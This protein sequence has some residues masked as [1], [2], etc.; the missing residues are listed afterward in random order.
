[1]PYQPD[2]DEIIFPVVRV[3]QR[4]DGQG[5]PMG[6]PEVWLGRRPEV[7][8]A[9]EIYQE[10]DPAGTAVSSVI[11]PLSEEESLYLENIVPPYHESKNKTAQDVLRA[12]IS[13]A[14]LPE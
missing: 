13:G 4:V 10:V 2:K 6:D 5:A 12:I 9:Q 7:A 3:R 1:M 14:G 8:Y 11:R